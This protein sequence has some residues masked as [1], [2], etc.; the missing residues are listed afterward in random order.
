[1][2][3]RIPTFLIGLVVPVVLVLFLFPLWNR[4]E[5]FVFGFP[6]NYFWLFLCMFVTSGCLLIAYKLDPLNDRE[7]E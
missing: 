2:R 5:P 3:S 1:M 6:F 7:D 4:V